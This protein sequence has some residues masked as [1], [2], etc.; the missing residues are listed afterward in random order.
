L[1]L[2]DESEAEN[3]CQASRVVVPDHIVADKQTAKLP[4]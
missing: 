1:G 4:V 2:F 3:R